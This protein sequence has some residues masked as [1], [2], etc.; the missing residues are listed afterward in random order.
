MNASFS[1]LALAALIGIGSAA[2][3]QAQAVD[4][5][6]A[7]AGAYTVDPYHTQVVFSVSHFG[8]TYYSGLFSSA[9]GSLQLDPAKLSTAKLDVSLP[10]AS[11]LTTST[12]LDGELKGDQWFDTAK[13]P[14]ATFT[15]TKVVPSG[16]DGATISGNLTMHGVTKPI[17]LT[18]HFV[19]AGN[20]PL[21]KAY[22]VGFQATGTI[23]RGEFGVKTY[24]PV[25]GDDVKLTIAGAFELKDK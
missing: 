20:N 11:V 7:K 12:Q 4:F 23:K 16:K 5:K 1:A 9:S 2:S 6:D 18:A 3:A 19:G 17:V 8:F 15:S 10:I 14:T 13:Y 22:T 21:S 24:L 25:V